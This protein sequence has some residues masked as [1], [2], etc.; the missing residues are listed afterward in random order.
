MKNLCGGQ[1]TICKRPLSPTT[2]RTHGTS[3]GLSGLEPFRRLLELLSVGV[4]FPTVPRHPLM[5]CVLQQSSSSFSLI[6]IL[7]LK[8]SRRQLLTH[9][10]LQTLSSETKEAPASP[11]AVATGGYELPNMGAGNQ[12]L[13]LQEQFVLLIANHLP[14]PQSLLY[15]FLCFSH[16]MASVVTSFLSVFPSIMSALSSILTTAFLIWG[17]IRLFVCLF[18]FIYR[19]LILSLLHL[20]CF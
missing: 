16:G 14:N 8:V 13:S 19:C 10:C 3:L 1:R 9:H 11:G 20:P 17:L 12:T 7:L 18:V 6:L 2:M 5:T 15:F 4:A